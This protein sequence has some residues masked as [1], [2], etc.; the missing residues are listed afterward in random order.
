MTGG[1]TF[2]RPE[3]IRKWRIA[4]LAAGGVT[5][6]EVDELED[7]LE[8]VEEDLLELLPPEEA[9]W[10]AAHRVGTPESL[11]REFAKV[12]TSTGW[13]LRVQWFLLGYVALELLQPLTQL[14]IGVLSGLLK[15]VP[16]LE[17]LA[18]LLFVVFVNSS[19]LLPALVAYLLIRR[20]RLEPA[21]LETWLAR[22]DFRGWWAFGLPLVA[23]A[24]WRLGL[25]TVQNMVLTPL[26]TDINASG[27]YGL[28]ALGSVLVVTICLPALAFLLVV[29]LQRH[30][31]P[32]HEA[33]LR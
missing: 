14:G 33:R 30:V 31:T 1:A 8:R 21:V 16:G 29:R 15:L 9:F 4:L 5:V 18:Q 27:A 19:Y 17:G 23:I 22:F 24:L 32:R 28:A 26:L 6:T 2:E 7:H 10:V 12:R 20:L 25:G 3:A 13:L 11:T